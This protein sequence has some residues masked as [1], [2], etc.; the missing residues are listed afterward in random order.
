MIVGKTGGVTGPQPIEPNRKAA[1]PKV[2]PTQETAKTDRADISP[3]ARLLQKIHEIPDIR[4]DKVE[5][6]RA[7]IEA[8]TY[9]TDDKLRSAVDKMFGDGLV[10]DNDVE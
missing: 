4:H 6:I 8:G 10:D 2:E 7:Q 3:Q 5:S 1:A 9:D